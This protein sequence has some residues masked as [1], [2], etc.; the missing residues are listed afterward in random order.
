MSTLNPREWFLRKIEAGSQMRFE[1]ERDGVRRIASMQKHLGVYKACILRHPLDYGHLDEGEMFGRSFATLND[2]ESWVS[3]HLE[4]DHVAMT[5]CKGHRSF[6]PD[7]IP[8][9]GTLVEI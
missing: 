3:S 1:L 2:A 9:D 7:N 8:E 4:T 5:V 6:E